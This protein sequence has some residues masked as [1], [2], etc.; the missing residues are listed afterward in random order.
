MH[1]RILGA[2]KTFAS[3]DSPLSDPDV[4]SRDELDA[5]LQ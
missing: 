3:L 4:E 2:E 1:Y 5:S